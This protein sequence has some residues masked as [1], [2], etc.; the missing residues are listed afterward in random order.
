MLKKIYNRL[1]NRV[2][3]DFLVCE[4][5]EGLE[6]FIKEEKGTFD[7]ETRNKYG[8]TQA[9]MIAQLTGEKGIKLF[10][11]NGGRFNPAAR[12]KNGMTEA[13]HILETCSDDAVELFVKHGG[14][15][16]SSVQ[17][18]SGRSEND[19]LAAYGGTK[20]LVLFEQ[21]GGKFDT[22]NNKYDKKMAEVAVELKQQQS[23]SNPPKP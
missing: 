2:L 11:E 21:Y 8:Q 3:E 6:K 5:L 18:N 20:A 22:A 16:N 12:D 1:N 14:R 15:F 17:D 19:I 23:K 7:T 9:M 13:M 10:V 4:R